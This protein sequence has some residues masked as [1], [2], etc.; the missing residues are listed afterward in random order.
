MA[1]AAALPEPPSLPTLDT[2]ADSTADTTV[3]GRLATRAYAALAAGERR[4]AARL[5]TLALSSPADPRA[6]AW[7]RERQRLVRRWS[8][9]A[10]TLLRAAGPV[11][12]AA[13]PVLGGGQSGASLAYTVNPLARRPLALVARINAASDSDGA[14]VA[15]S[16]QA[17]FGLRWQPH[18]GLSL[19]AER[20]VA[21]GADVGDDWTLRLAGGGTRR[22]GRLALD[23]YAE[24]GAL[25]RGPLFAGGQARL[26]RDL[27][28]DDGATLAAGVG[29]WGSVQGD[30]RGGPM[31]GRFDLGP[32]AALRV[33][34]GRATL[35][36]VADYRVRLAGKAA[37]GNGP[38]LT[39][40]LAF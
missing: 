9:D 12:P 26:S 5:F 37:P 7:Q 19:S 34:M 30:R 16:T 40:S 32:A 18:P 36:V 20:L 10:W 8:G 6:A 27:L 24:A 25:A 17:A 1:L 14:P 3:S 11:A 2:T 29:A 23:G 38:S 28:A 39:V 21:I 4:E 15:T 13:S 31:L 35:A 22:R 33:P